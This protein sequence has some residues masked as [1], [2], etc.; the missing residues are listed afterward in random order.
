MAVVASVTVAG[1][2][3]ATW[4]D[5]GAGTYRE[6]APDGTTVTLTR[7]YTAV[8]S[9]Q[10]AERD[11]RAA[12]QANYDALRT[13]AIAAVGA[14]RTS[15]RT[16]TTARGRTD[17]QIA[18]TTAAIAASIRGVADALLVA[19]DALVALARLIGPALDTTDTGP[20]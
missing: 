13:K 8:E 2:V 18:G 5:A 7:A 14:V 3:R 19:D 20:A 15:A 10:K 11:A 6:Y 17:T 16:V 12:Q 1:V 4:D 9:A